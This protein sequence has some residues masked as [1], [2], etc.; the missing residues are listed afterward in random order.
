M[1]EIDPSSLPLDLAACYF[2]VPWRRYDAVSS[3]EEWAND[4]GAWKYFNDVHGTKAQA[5]EI[6]LREARR[7]IEFVTERA[8]VLALEKSS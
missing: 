7:L 5:T 4:V 1:S 2:I 3:V 6:A 8:A